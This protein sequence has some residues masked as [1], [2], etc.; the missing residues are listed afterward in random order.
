MYEDIIDAVMD[1]YDGED[2][3]AYED[4]LRT[5]INDYNEEDN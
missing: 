4:E 2:P 5:S 1:A 3:W